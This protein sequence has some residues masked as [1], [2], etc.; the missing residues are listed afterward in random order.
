MSAVCQI[1]KLPGRVYQ[2]LCLKWRKM[3][4]ISQKT[5]LL[6][7]LTGRI[8]SDILYLHILYDCNSSMLTSDPLTF[9]REQRQLLFSAIQQNFQQP[10]DYALEDLKQLPTD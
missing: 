7:L 3:P 6:A 9:I 10:R 5:E 1:V 8:L 4:R 2:R